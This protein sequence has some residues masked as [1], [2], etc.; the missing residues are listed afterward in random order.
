MFQGIHWFNYVF[1]FITVVMVAGGAYVVH[2][3]HARR[4]GGSGIDAGQLT[5]MRIET[6][7]IG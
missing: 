1:F 4:S 3:A 7:A 6:K 2:V 5:Q